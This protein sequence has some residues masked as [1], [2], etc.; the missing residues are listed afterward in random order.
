MSYKKGVDVSKF[1]GEIDWE[2]VKASGIDFAIIQ[3]GL[4]QGHI[5]PQYERNISEC[6]RLGI[7]CGVYWFSYA[8]TPEWAAKEAEY[9][10]SAIAPYKLDYPIC[11]DFEYDSVSWAQKNGVTVTKELA[12]EIV[13]AF[14]GAIEATGHWVMNYSNPDFLNRYFDSSLM[15]VSF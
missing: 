6:N 14:C 3:A 1:Q 13:T 11:F 4:G 5:D 12:T 8:Y 10:L 15:R 2:T 9:C 7:P